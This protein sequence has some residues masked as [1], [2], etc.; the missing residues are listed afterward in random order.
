MI[1]YYENIAW[2]TGQILATHLQNNHQVCICN[3]LTFG[4][5]LIE[6]DRHS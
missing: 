6:D 3:W 4:V 2:T 5:D 1:V